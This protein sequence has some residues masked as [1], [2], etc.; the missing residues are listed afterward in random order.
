[1]LSAPKCP[2]CGAPARL[3]ARRCEYCDSD[4]Y[5]DNLDVADALNL[6]VL[7]RYMAH[8]SSQ[9]TDPASVTSLVMCQL[10]LGLFDAAELSSQQALAFAP[11]NPELLFCAAAARLRRRRP[12]SVPFRDA[13][14]IDGRLAAAIQLR[15][16]DSRYLWAAALFKHDFYVKNGLRMPPPSV[17]EIVAAIPLDPDRLRALDRSL[18]WF[19]VPDHSEITGRD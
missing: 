12:K 6:P 8:F 10:R 9:P 7:Q 1:M 19:P 17:Q 15:P 13:Q 14:F 5:V 11:A 4:Y 3:E 2:S 18:H 16:N